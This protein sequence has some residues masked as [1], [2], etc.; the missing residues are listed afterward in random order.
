[1]S[2]YFK[3]LKLHEPL[4][5]ISECNFS[6][7]KYSLMQNSQ[8]QINFRFNGKKLIQSARAAVGSMATGHNGML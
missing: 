3:K 8:V 6:F 7:L 4:H 5:S 2:E 1:M